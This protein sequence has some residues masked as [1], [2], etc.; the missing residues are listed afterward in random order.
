MVRS[1][2]VALENSWAKARRRGKVIRRENFLL[3]RE[4]ARVIGESGGGGLELLRL[5]RK[6]F[7]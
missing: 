6:N 3:E 2:G 5:M 4:A 1:V 7:Y